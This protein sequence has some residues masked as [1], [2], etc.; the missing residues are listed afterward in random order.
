MPWPGGREHPAKRIGRPLALPAVVLVAWW[1]LTATS[2]PVVDPLILPA[3]I[4]VFEALSTVLGSSGG[5][6]DAIA[7]TRRL[8]VTLV[9][10]AGIGIPLGLWLG[11][12]RTLYA[13]FEAPLNA[14]RSVPAAALFP[15]FL[16]VIGVGERSIVSLAAYNAVTVL[17]IYTAAGAFLSMSS[18]VEQARVLG[19]S[20]GM[21]ALQVLYWEALPQISAGLRVASGYALALI[22]A[23]EMFI[24]TSNLG[25]GRRIFEYQAS[26]RIPETYASILVAAA[27]GVLV[28]AGLTRIERHFLRWLP[29]A[30]RDGG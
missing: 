25:L 3:P 24:G 8:L 10:S 6:H 17:I 27:L 11:T 29:P 28:N 22:I 9:V 26:Y 12:Q 23:V 21:V 13:Y 20:R 19:L 15:L 18:R 30:S 2:H 5:L 7:T 14:L 16:I 4:R 1:L